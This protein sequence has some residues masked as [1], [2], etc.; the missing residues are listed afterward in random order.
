[1]N[2]IDI[3][4]YHYVRDLK[5]SR[6]PEIKGLDV[7]LFEQQIQFFLK[8]G[9][10]VTMEQVLE[11]VVSEENKLPEHAVLLTFDDGYID[12]YLYVYPILKKY[13]IQGSFF[14]SG[15]TFT[16]HKLLD[17][18]KIHFILACADMD[19][20]MKDLLSEL[21]HYRK[22]GYEYPSNE[23]LLETYAVANR[24]D[25]K[26]VIFVKRVLQTAIPEEVRN[27]I[28][29]KLFEKYV[30]VSETVFAHELYLNQA[31]IKCMKDGGMHIGVHGYD[32]YWLGNLSEEKMKQ[33]VDSALE[34]MKDF[35]DAD[36]WVM[37][38]PYGSYNAAVIDYVKSKGCKAGI[39]T[40]V[41]AARIGQDN[42]Y[43]L[44]R[45]DCNDF[46]PK[47]NRYLES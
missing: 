21:D 19:K 1:M 37:N 2:K 7:K 41:R 33:D 34:I 20:L 40:E 13:G 22:L 23:E 26:E 15:K 27:I 25:T 36:N 47:S 29:S 16:E 11:A 4:M 44:P 31:Q 43:I 46:P 38:Y 10:V 32:H 6:Y 45:W 30:G 9:T 14:I 42:P 28:S 39:S 17:V 18:N 24:F 12:N 8:Y 5:N 3:I 35:I